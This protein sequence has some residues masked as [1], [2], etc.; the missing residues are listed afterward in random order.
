[1]SIHEIFLKP[2]LIIMRFSQYMCDTRL[3]FS[4]TDKSSEARP[5]QQRPI[6]SHIDKHVL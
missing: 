6:M 4:R 2:Q 1:M 3:F 5:K